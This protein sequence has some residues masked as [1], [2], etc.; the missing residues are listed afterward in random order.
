MVTLVA[1]LWIG[2]VTAVLVFCVE[3]ASWA[4]GGRE[5]VGQGGVSV[6]DCSVDFGSLT[7]ME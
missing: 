2:Q 7:A 3:V 6:G 1:V 5:G 4:G